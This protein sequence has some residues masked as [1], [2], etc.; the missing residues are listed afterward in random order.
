VALCWGQ[1]G[2]IGDGQTIDRFT[3]KAVAGGL[4]FERVTA[5]VLHTCGETTTNRA[6]CWGVNGRGQL[7]DGGPPELDQLSPVAVVGG[8]A[9]AQLSA[10]A[11]HTCGVTPSDVAFCWGYDFFGQLGHGQSGFGAESRRPVRVDDS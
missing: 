2:L 3:P 8:H 11:A 7:G 1:G 6:Y 5:G 4:D 10:G 9:F